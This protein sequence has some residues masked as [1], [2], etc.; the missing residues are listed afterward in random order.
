MMGTIN[1]AKKIFDEHV[2]RVGAAL[3]LPTRHGNPEFRCHH[4]SDGVMH[5]GT[6]IYWNEELKPLLIGTAVREHN[7]TIF[8]V[9]DRSDETPAIHSYVDIEL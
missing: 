6:F 2:R 5:G 7:H 3:A 8:I 4:D 1:T 9:V